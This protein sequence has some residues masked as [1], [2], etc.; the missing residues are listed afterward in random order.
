MK[1]RFTIAAVVAALVMGTPLAAAEPVT[2]SWVTATRDGVVRIAPCGKSLCGTLARFLVTPPGGADQRDVH[3]PDAKL[4]TRKLLGVPI[5]T[6]FSEDGTV[7]RGTIYDPKSGKSYRSVLRRLAGDRLE[8]K[9][10]IG[11]FCQTQVW[12]RGS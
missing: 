7:W 12:R 10:C 11:P 1:H 6:G 5:L 2:G 8:V 3:N 9:G 4:R